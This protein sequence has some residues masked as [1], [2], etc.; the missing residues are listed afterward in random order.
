[1]LLIIL[2]KHDNIVSLKNKYRLSEE[3]SDSYT[4][5]FLNAKCSYI[6]VVYTINNTIP[7]DTGTILY[8]YTMHSS[9][10][11]FVILI[12]C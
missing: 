3:I 2:R 7:N 10:Q 6:K 4:I 5:S 9:A 11:L 1:M 8:Y 12:P